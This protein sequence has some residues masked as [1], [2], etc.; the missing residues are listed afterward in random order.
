[1]ATI[2]T[3]GIAA[4]DIIN[5][6]EHYP[7][8]DDEVRATGQRIARGGNAANTAEVLARLGHTTR[9]AGTL[10]DDADSDRIRASFRA[11]G[12]DFAGARTVP[13]G[14]VPTSYIT[15]S[16]ATGSRTIVH[17]RDLPELDAAHFARL[18]LADLDWLHFEGR[19]VEELAAMV[20]HARQRRPGLPLSIEAEKPRPGLEA[21]LER[22]DVVFFSRPWAEAAGHTDPAAFLAATLPHQA[23][24]VTW[25]AEGAH[26]A[27]PEEAPHHHPAA[28]PESVVD[29]IGAGDAFNA[30]ALHALAGGGDIHAAARSGNRL[31]GLKCGVEGFAF[32][33][34]SWNSLT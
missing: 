28:P 16:R 33:R 12:V 10:G 8:E 22:A 31:A 9:W 11:A 20:D 30:G 27:G 14:R 29:T 23:R 3:V 21:V 17:H 24:T 26:A 6:V 5:T 19:N 15:A 34:G 7:A 25:G 18:D 2:L 1:M 32:P 13:G 4:L